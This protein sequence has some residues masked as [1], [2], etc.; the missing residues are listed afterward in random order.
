MTAP[1][2]SS[3]CLEGPPEERFDEKYNKR[4]EFPTSL[5][6]AILLH[7]LV[8]AT[9]VFLLVYVLQG[10]GDQ[11]SM[12][13]SLVSLQGLDD[14]GA[15]SVGSSRNDS[16]QFFKDESLAEL[17]PGAI[18]DPTTLPEIKENPLPPINPANKENDKPAEKPSGGKQGTGPAKGNGDSNVQGPGP[19]GE[20]TDSTQARNM[21]WVL[22]FK[23]DSGRDYLAQLKAM[24]AEVL[25]PIPETEK[26]IL[27][28]DLGKPKEQKQ[29]TD[30]DMKRLAKKVKFSDGRREAVGAVAQTLGLE[31]TP[32]SFW[33]FFPKELE[34]DLAKKELSYRNRR[35]EDIEE[36]IFTVVVKDGKYELRVVEQKIKK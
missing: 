2:E 28:A 3:A 8:G 7:V 22:R 13:M 24:G 1:F 11:P 10:E 12:K 20:G 33:A 17:K 31:F 9:L 6:S 35:S 29:A 27:I 34:E 26:Y 14:N 18:V 21:R 32:Q 16:D 19:G 5:V 36:T 30:D 4:L 25:I 15:G 23:V